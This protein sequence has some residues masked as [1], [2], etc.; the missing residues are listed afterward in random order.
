MPVPATDIHAISMPKISIISINSSLAALA[1]IY[2]RAICC[3]YRWAM[4]LL[5][6][7]KSTREYI[8]FSY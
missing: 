1:R 7:I 3:S 6:P 5:L 4:H 2:G 8:E